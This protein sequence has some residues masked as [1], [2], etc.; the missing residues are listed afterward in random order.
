MHQNNFDFMRLFAASIVVVGHA[1]PIMGIRQPELLGNPISVF[2][3]IIFF[4]ISGYLIAGSWTS[5]PSPFRF[6]LKRALRIFPALIVVVCITAFALGPMESTLSTVDYFN[7]E[8]T[9]NYLRNAGLY[10]VYD[11]PDVFGS[12]PIKSAVNGS[13]WSLPA[14]FFMYLLTPVILILA[15]RRRGSVY[16]AAATTFSCTAVY[17]TY[18]Y[19]G[20]RLVIYATEV[21]AACAMG[22]YF[23]AGSFFRVIEEKITFDIRLVALVLVAHAIST[24]WFDGWTRYLVGVTSAFSIPYVVLGI[25]KRSTPVI[26][27]AGSKG[28]FSYGLYLYAFPIQQSIS[29][30]FPDMNVWTSIILAFTFTAPCAIGSW[31]LIEKRAMKAKRF[32]V[33]RMSAKAAPPEP[34]EAAR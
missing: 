24:Y 27:A 7:N 29:A 1:F 28:D 3:V 30:Y 14:E 26:R 8:R 23:M 31:H 5:D 11:L 15:G 19:S 4:S 16:A 18:F 22:A 6:F 33:T 32:A 17:L 9:Y 21:R 13:L 25:A 34:T 2:G 20:P 12:N 10:I